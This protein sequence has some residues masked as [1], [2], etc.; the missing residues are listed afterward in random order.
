MYLKKLDGEV[1]SINTEIVKVNDIFYFQR[2]Q[3]K[4]LNVYKTAQNTF[5]KENSAIKILLMLFFLL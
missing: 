1:S 4:T 3:K 2:V 5:S